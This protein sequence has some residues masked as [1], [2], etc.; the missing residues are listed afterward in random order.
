MLRQT[1]DFASGVIC[2]SCRV[3]RSVR[4]AKYRSTIFHVRVGPIRIQQNRVGTRYAELVFLYLLGPMGHVVLSEAQNIYTLFFML[5]RDRFG[6]N[7]KRARRYYAELVFLHP[8]GSAGHVVYSG[9]SG[10]RNVDALFFML[11]WALCGF[12]KSTVGHIL[13]TCAFTSGGICVS[14]SA[15]R[16]VRGSKCQRTIFHA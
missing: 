2:G 11:G 14:H 6:F 9:S 3:F 15:Y 4:G 16:C 5:G 8:V 7:K 10:A 13:P 12:I 1:C